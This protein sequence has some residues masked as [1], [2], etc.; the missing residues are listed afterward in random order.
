MPQSNNGN[1]FAS[2]FINKV[3]AQE[4]LKVNS[5]NFD[6]SDSIIFLGT[7]GNDESELKITKKV[8]SEPDR[9]FFDIENAIITFP[10]STFELKNSRLTKVRIAQNSVDPNVVRIVIWNNP[11]YDSSQIKV[12][13]IKNN[14]N[15]NN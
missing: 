15:H 7:S 14:K 2:I 9:V 11:N 5:I 4:S 6:N 3:Y 12:L 10:N 1:N 13:Q 8:L